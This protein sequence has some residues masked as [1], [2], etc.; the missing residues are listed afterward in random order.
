MIETLASGHGA[1][2]TAEPGDRHAARGG[3]EVLHMVGS[4]HLDHVW[5]WR[6]QEGYQEA[7]ATFASAADR[8]DE[9]PEFIFTADSMAYFAMVEESDPDLFDR[10]R[11]RVAQ[12]RCEPIGGWWVEPDCNLPSGESFVRQ[13]LYGQRWLHERFGRLA[14]VG[15][16]FDPFGHAGVLPQILRGQRMDGYVFMR[17]GPHEKHLP[18][19]IFRWRSADGSGV[20]AYRIPHEYRSAGDTTE[21]HVTWVLEKVPSG[22]RELMCFYGVGNHGGGPTKANIESIREIDGTNGIHLRHSTPPA[23][24][25]TVRQSGV[26][27]PEMDG[28]LQFHAVGCYS[29]HSGIKAAHRRAE[30]A[31][32]EAEKWCVVA[33]AVTG[34]RYP[35][36]ELTGSWKLLLLNQFHDILGGTSLREACDDAVR[37]LG[38]VTAGA[39]RVAN[40]AR[41]QLSRRIEIAHEPRYQPVVVF[42]PHPWPVRAAAEVELEARS[43]AEVIDETGAAVPTQRVRADA[44]VTV[45]RRFAFPVELPPLGYRTYRLRWASDAPLPAP[46]GE[47]VLENRYLRAEVDAGSGVLRSLVHKGSGTDVLAGGPHAVVYHD[48]SDTWSHGV[49]GYDQVAGTFEPASVRLLENGPVRDRVRVRSE[50][51][52]SVLIEDYVLDRELDRLRVDVT[53]DWRERHAL[54]KLRFPTVLAEP[55]ATYETPYG[56]E[57]RAVDGREVPMQSFADVSGLLPSGARAGLTVVNDGKYSADARDGDLGLTVARSPVYAWHDPAIPEDGFDYDYLDQGVQRFS[58]W[59]VPHAGPVALPAAV[60]AGLEMNQPPVVQLETFH[61]GT[62]PPSAGF[63]AEGGGSVVVTACKQAEDSGEVVVRARE[64]AGL[65]AVLHLELPMLDGR[66]VTAEF[67][68]YEIATLLVPDDARRP[69]RRVDLL[70]WPGSDGE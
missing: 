66:I 52:S 23:F 12:G 39:E 33:S 56:H 48:P 18:D 69:V 46:Q 35:A 38:S 47:P 20:L 2:G 10:I 54:L 17:P 60:R 63:A 70:E 50:Y 4:A 9:Y 26:D 15:S 14:R 45:R 67:G 62:L 40:Y 28:E 11:E 13:G 42:N 59:L 31:L 19:E 24:F 21:R 5:L 64:T 34:A 22:H 68:P 36:E 65:P 25:E 43:D 41:Q 8:L 51:G 37:D 58:Y 49:S 44:V 32:L 29:A 7:R 3:P 6:W 27:V 16:N 1:E 53:L 55:V 57:V 30:N 61:P